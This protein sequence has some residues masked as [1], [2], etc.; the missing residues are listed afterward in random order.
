[1]QPDIG[2]LGDMTPEA[3]RRYGH[4]V[5][6]WIAHYLANVDRYPVLA[7]VAQALSSGNCRPRRRS[8]PSRW[9]RRC[10]TSSA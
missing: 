7:Q 10:L 8:R 9:N 3:F 4:Q 1:M 5:V 2:P 6:D